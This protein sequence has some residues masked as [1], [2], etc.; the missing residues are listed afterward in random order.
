[1]VA[2]VMMAG[3]VIDG[4]RLFWTKRRMQGAADAGAIAAALEMQ[5][6]NRQLLDNLR[7]A[8]VQDTGLNGFNDENSTITVNSPPLAGRFAG[9]ANYVEVQIQQNV[10]TTFASVLHSGDSTVAAR[11]VAGLVQYGD[12]CILTLNES[13]RAAMR[14]HGNPDIEANCG[15][16]SNSRHS[17]GLEFDGAVTVKAKWIGVAGDYRINGASGNIEPTPSGDALPQLDPLANMPPVDYSTW[18]PASY[19]KKTGKVTCPSG[20]CVFHKQLTITNPKHKVVFPEGTY[21]LMD[22]MHIAKGPV[23]GFGVMF[24][25]AGS[26]GIKITGDATFTPPTSGTYQGVLMFADRNQ[27]NVTNNIGRGSGDFVWKGL[28]YFPSQHLDFSGRFYGSGEGDP[29]SWGF[30]V[31]DTLDFSGNTDMH[32]NQPQKDEAPIYLTKTM[33]AE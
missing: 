26:R 30:I 27:T 12:A 17:R 19:N 1:M 20:Q 14:F 25:S 10:P 24:Y 7:P 13:D 15:L 22:G 4:G 33:L 6:G 5:R 28:L 9:D 31:S 8:A 11:S 29:D 3:L 23:E 16:M 18:P 32:F 2:F 21:V